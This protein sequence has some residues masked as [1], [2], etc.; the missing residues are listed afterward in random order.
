MVGDELQLVADAST[1]RTWVL[2]LAYRNSGRA[3]SAN[4]PGDQSAGRP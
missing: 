3:L 4:P 1:K 2:V